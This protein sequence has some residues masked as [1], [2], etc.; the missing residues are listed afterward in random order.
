MSIEIGSKVKI[1]KNSRFCNPAYNVPLNTEGTI[2]SKSAYNDIT[3]DFGNNIKTSCNIKEIVSLE[4]YDKEIVNIN[5]ITI[6]SI[7]SEFGGNWRV[8]HKNIYDSTDTI[9]RFIHSPTANC[10]IMSLSPAQYLFQAS[11]FPTLEHTELFLKKI[12]KEYCSKNLLFIDIEPKYDKEILKLFGKE[13]IH[14]KSPYTNITGNN[15]ILYL[16]KM[17]KFRK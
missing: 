14:L 4:E 6:E 10:Q 13:N 15:L 1:S 11:Y 5:N 16:L 2:T 7:N 3:V 12:I 8:K 9:I 17:E